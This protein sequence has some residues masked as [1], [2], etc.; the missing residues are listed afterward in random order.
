MNSIL[1]KFI[2]KR[3]KVYLE[4]LEFCGKLE[5]IDNMFISI[6]D[7]KGKYNIIS[8]IEVVFIECDE[9]KY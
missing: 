1:E 7:S 4:N 8:I 3:I 2:G 6:I 9:N 5:E